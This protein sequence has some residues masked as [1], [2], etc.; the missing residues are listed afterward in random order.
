MLMLDIRLGGGV[1]GAVN[2]GQ[3]LIRLL[4]Q[5]QVSVSMDTARAPHRRQ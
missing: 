1:M 2:E 4:A 3:L 5:P